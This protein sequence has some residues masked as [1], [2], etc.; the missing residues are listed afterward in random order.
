MI[1]C[2]AC[3]G[4]CYPVTKKM[5]GVPPVARHDAHFTLVGERPTASGRVSTA[6]LP[7]AKN[8]NQWDAGWTFSELVLFEDQQILPF[9]ILQLTK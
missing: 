2:F 1:A 5:L 6:L 4:Q 8:D 9:A 7:V 3:Y